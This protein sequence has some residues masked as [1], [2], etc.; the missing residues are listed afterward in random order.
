MRHAKWLAV[1]V[2]GLLAAQASDARPRG[3]KGLLTAKPLASVQLA[4]Q[5]AQQDPAA[6]QDAKAAAALK[7]IRL[8]YQLDPRLT[9]SLYMGERWVTPDTYIRV[10]EGKEC[11]AEVRVEGVDGKGKLVKIKP[12]WTASDPGMVTIAPSAVPKSQDR[13]FKITVRRAG[14]STLKVTAT[15]SPPESKDA[16]SAPADSK[17]STDS[18]EVSKELLVKAIQRKDALQI[19]ISPKKESPRP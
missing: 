1:V 2:I 17:A 9:K 10:G 12:Q 6:K 5:A 8:V 19:A 18:T 3:K 16:G 15:T 11:T 4:D 14:E 7:E 13:Q